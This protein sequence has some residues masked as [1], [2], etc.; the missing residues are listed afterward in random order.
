MCFGQD[1]QA[2]LGWCWSLLSLTNSKNT[3]GGALHVGVHEQSAPLLQL[4]R[5]GLWFEDKCRDATEQGMRYDVSAGMP[6][7]SG[8]VC[9]CIQYLQPTSKGYVCSW[10]VSD[11]CVL[12]QRQATPEVAC[13][14]CHIYTHYQVLRGFVAV[15]V[16]FLLPHGPL[17]LVFRQVC[18]DE[19][20]GAP[21]GVHQ[22]CTTLG[23]AFNGLALQASQRTPRQALLRVCSFVG[24]L[25]F[26]SPSY[27]LPPCPRVWL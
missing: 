25:L 15:D 24:R 22:S 17:P 6:P 21:G 10:L 20:M 26:I 13:V 4:L 19:L 16:F 11:L 9:V 5:P 23:K 18:V 1:V 14:F 3:L 12:M 27:M 8:F 7:A 2:C